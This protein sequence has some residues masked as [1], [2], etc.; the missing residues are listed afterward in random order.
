ME[1]VWQLINDYYELLHEKDMLSSIRQDQRLTWFHEMI[2]HM[3][4]Q[5]FYSQPGISDQIKTVENKVISGQLTPFVAAQSL[6]LHKNKD[7]K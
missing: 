5:E 1:D 6:V 4:K 7:S 3:L 2:D